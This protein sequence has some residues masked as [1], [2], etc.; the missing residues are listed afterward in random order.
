MKAMEDISE[1]CQRPFVGRRILVVEDSTVIRLLIVHHLARAGAEVFEAT[2]G[3]D[4]TDLVLG[5]EAAPFD[6]IVMDLQMPEVNGCDATRRIRAAGVDVPILALTA[7]ASTVDRR[8]CLDA[9]CT[10]YATKPISGEALLR[11]C[12]R[13]VN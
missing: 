9:G 12:R 11:M 4:A 5:A 2:D 3:G 6:L 13:L 8:R 7:H 10:E 1:S